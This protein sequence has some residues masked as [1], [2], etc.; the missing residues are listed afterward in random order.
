MTS[1]GKNTVKGG[2]AYDKKAYGSNDIS[3]LDLA[4][5]YHKDSGDR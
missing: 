4:F 3:C 2:F 1:L 5:P